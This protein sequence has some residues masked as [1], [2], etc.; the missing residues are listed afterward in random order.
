MYVICRK[1]SATKNRL[2]DHV[3][4]IFFEISWIGFFCQHHTAQ[5]NNKKT[6]GKKLWGIITS[7]HS[8]H[9]TYISVSLSEQP[10]ESSNWLFHLECRVMP[11]PPPWV[12][13]AEI[14]SS[15]IIAICVIELSP[16]VITL[17]LV[18]MIKINLT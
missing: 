9:S 12:I 14:L 4:D 6:E 17:Y 8:I 18:F 7:H 3:N 10:S 1:N 2:C 16:K 5:P 11:P 13:A 15:S